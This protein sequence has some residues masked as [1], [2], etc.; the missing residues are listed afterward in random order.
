MKYN[1]KKEEILESYQKKIWVDLRMA[2]KWPKFIFRVQV[3]EHQI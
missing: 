2:K 1:G 3:H